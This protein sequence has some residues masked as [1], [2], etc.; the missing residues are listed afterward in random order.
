MAPSAGDAAYV[1]NPTGAAG[2]AIGS[3]NYVEHL[4]TRSSLRSR[5]AGIDQRDADRLC[6]VL[7]CAGSNRPARRQRR[8][9]VQRHAAERASEA[10]SNATGVNLDEEMTLL[11][12]IERSYQASTKLIATIDN[13]FEA[14]LSAAV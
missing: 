2:L 1:Y 4:S 8:C 12:E 3:S 6:L 14:L 7:R 13:M 11:L 5:G 10:L 9:R